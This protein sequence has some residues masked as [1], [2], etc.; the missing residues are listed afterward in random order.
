MNTRPIDL[1]LP[2][3]DGSDPAW[4]AEKNRYDTDHTVSDVRFES[5]DN[6]QYVF[7]GIEKFMPWVHHVFLSPGDI[8]RTGLIH[9]VKDCGLSGTAIIFRPAICRRLIPM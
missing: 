8:C 3:V 4:R 9:R 6:L 2:W 5:W 1:V 7:R